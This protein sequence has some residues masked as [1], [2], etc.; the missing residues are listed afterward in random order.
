MRILVHII[1]LFNKL[2]KFFK[3]KNKWNIQRSAS[4]IYISFFLCGILC[5]FNI[6]LAGA[7]FFIIFFV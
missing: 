7:F 6:K 4:V 5:K 1:D 2:S 3:E